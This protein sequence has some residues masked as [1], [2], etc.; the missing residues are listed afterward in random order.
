MNS[1]GLTHIF[2]PWPD[3]KWNFIFAAPNRSV[4]WHGGMMKSLFFLQDKPY[5]FARCLIW[6]FCLVGCW[7]FFHLDIQSQADIKM[8][9]FSCCHVDGK[10]FCW[11]M[12]KSHTHSQLFSISR[13]IP[14]R[15]L[16]WREFWD[17]GMGIDFPDVTCT[18][19]IST[20]PG[21]EP[22][23]TLSYCEIGPIQEVFATQYSTTFT[24]NS[25][26][27]FSWNHAL[28]LKSFYKLVSFEKIR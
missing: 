22:Q 18:A 13:H 14:L 15:V 12:P 1:Q 7:E 26:I 4:T 23:I 2:H 16:T 20:L 17:W 25:N 11:K 21:S 6:L 27:L 5:I 3:E 10:K 24:L 9:L 8:F 28:F 19:A